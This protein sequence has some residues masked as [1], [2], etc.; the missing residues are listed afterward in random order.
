MMKNWLYGLARKAGFRRNQIKSEIVVTFPD[1]SQIRPDVGIYDRHGRL[2]IALE[3]FRTSAVSR[4]KKQ[5]SRKYGF[6]I[7]EFCVGDSR[8]HVYQR[9]ILAKEFLEWVKRKR[10]QN[11][12]RPLWIPPEKSKIYRVQ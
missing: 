7:F 9:K 6:Q 3:G 4:R 1:G 5:L 12:E 11:P 10:Q 8:R 2:L